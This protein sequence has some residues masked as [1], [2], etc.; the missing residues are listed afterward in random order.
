MANDFYSDLEAFNRF[1]AEHRDNGSEGLS[2][3]SSLAAFRA[4]QEDLQRL[5]DHLEP[6][7][8]QAQRG[9]SKPLDVKALIDR[10]STADAG[11]SAGV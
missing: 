7:I 5:R 4:H 3:E 2:L 6:S 1:V 8:A 11:K 9:E 10:A